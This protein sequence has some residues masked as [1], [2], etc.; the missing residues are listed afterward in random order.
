MAKSTSPYF[1]PRK[2]RPRPS[3]S[4]PKEDESHFGVAKKKSTTTKRRKI[5]TSKKKKTTTNSK[6][7]SISELKSPVSC[8]NVRKSVTKR[9]RVIGRKKKPG[10]VESDRHRCGPFPDFHRPTP[11]DCAQALAELESMHGVY[12]RGESGSVLDSLVRTMLS[13]NTTDLTS[14]RAFQQLK[15]RFPSWDEVL[16]ADI[17]DLVESVRC[18]G[19]ADIRANRIRTILTTLLQDKANGNKHYALSNGW[20]SLDNS[21]EHLRF[22]SDEIVKKELLRFKGVGPKTVA[23]VLMFCLG[24][25][26]FPVDVHVWRI[27]RTRL[28]WAPMKANREQTYEHLNSRIPA[29]LKFNLHV[30][31]VEHGKHCPKCCAPGKNPRREILGPCPLGS[32]KKQ[33]ER[34]VTINGKSSKSSD[35]NKLSK[36]KKTSMKNA[37][38]DDKENLNE[39]DQEDDIEIQRTKTSDDVINDKFERAEKS[40]QIVQVS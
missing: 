39:T 4:Q 17:T 27:T 15:T 19:L 11:E 21:L 28:K 5:T 14:H 8:G 34:C 23:C 35:L 29:E 36:K 9:E 16:P 24:R 33:F 18:C 12:E 10:V 30:A 26:E 1:S 25:S 7:R 22:V 38:I 31:L 40:G 20:T 6:K 3:T 32:M 2:L 37:T 13:Q